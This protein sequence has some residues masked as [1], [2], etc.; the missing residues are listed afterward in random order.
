MLGKTVQASRLQNLHLFIIGKEIE[1]GRPK[2]LGA[3]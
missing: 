1:P 2:G 3:C